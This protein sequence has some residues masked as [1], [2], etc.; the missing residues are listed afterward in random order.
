MPN[1]S[2]WHKYKIFYF[3]SQQQSS[4][5]NFVQFAFSRCNR[6]FLV[7]PPPDNSTVKLFFVKVT[8][9]GREMDIEVMQEF[10]HPQ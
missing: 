2:W 6:F 3:E 9:Q 8:Y 10:V 4:Q 7:D 5:P 1:V